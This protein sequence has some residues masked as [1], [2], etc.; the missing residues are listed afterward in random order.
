MSREILVK[1]LLILAQS[2]PWTILIGYL[3]FRS[4]WVVLPAFMAIAVL[5]LMNI[6]CDFCKTSLTDEKIYKHFRLIKFFDTKFVDDCPVCHHRM[7]GE[8]TT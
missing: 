4:Q 2:S 3:I 5:I 6:R 8:R 7:F 1:A